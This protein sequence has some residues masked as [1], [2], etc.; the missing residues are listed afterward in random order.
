MTE[1]VASGLLDLPWYLRPIAGGDGS[2]ESSDANTPNDNPGSSGPDDGT[3]APESDTDTSHEASDID[4]K[5]RYND[6]QPEFTRVTQEA[7]QLRQIIELARAGDPEALDF[8]GWE[9]PDDEEFDEDELT[10]EER[11]ERKLAEHEQVLES[12]RSEREQHEI[13]EAASRFYES[14][15]AKLDPKSEWDEEYRQLVVRV[16]DDFVDEQGFPNLSA[17]HEAIQAQF[18]REFK[19]RVQRKRSAHQVRSGASASHE[20]DLDTREGRREHMARRLVEQE[21]PELL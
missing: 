15:L 19:A 3:P 18:E 17:A 21:T 11:L 13:Q 20:P 7:A 16:A 8:L 12:I 9:A 10:A 4:Y 1:E 6:L 2:E 14:E 5:K